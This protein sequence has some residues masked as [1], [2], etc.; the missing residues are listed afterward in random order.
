[1]IYYIEDT[2]KNYQPPIHI[3]KTQISN[4]IG[5][6]V[7]WTIYQKPAM[8][9]IK[10]NIKNPYRY[11]DKNEFQKLLEI[12]PTLK[13]EDAAYAL[14]YF[15][16]IIFESDSEKYLKFIKRYHHELYLELSRSDMDDKIYILNIFPKKIYSYSE[17]ELRRRMAFLIFA[18]IFDPNNETIVIFPNEDMIA[19]TLQWQYEQI[20]ENINVNL[21]F[22]NIIPKTKYGIKFSGHLTPETI[23]SVD[24]PIKSKLIV[25]KNIL[26]YLQKPAINFDNEPI[27]NLDIFN[28]EFDNYWNVFDLKFD[29]SYELLKRQLLYLQPLFTELNQLRKFNQKNSSKALKDQVRNLRTTIQKQETTIEQL[30]K[31]IDKLKVDNSKLQ[32]SLNQAYKNSAQLENLK[33][34]KVENETFIDL[35]QNQIKQLNNQLSNQPNIEKTDTISAEK[36]IAKLKESKILIVSGSNNWNNKLKNI[37]PNATILDINKDFNKEN[38]NVDYILFNTQIN[39]HRTYYKIKLNLSKNTK[40]LYI[41]ES[42]NLNRI[43]FE[44]NQQI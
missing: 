6:M 41:N 32:Q 2:N 27:E 7:Q 33:Q 16:S 36:I 17:Y 21:N 19:M 22:K 10:Q 44:I 11:Q 42:T 20:T 18:N 1:M 26:R 25:T 15:L 14:T 37:L 13:Q 3:I 39:N 31:E 5:C 28:N 23:L 4:A 8:Q 35:L 9:F 24:E 29:E 12:F 34:T 38:L 30:N 40:L 43:L